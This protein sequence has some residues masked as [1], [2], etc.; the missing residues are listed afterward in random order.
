MSDNEK[1]YE[2]EALSL[3]RTAFFGV[4]LSTTATL[5][6]VISVPMLYNY[7]QHV[8]SIMQ[9][10]VD[11]C[12]SRSGSIWREVTHTQGLARVPDRS[13]RSR[14]Y[15]KHGGGKCC[16]C[17]VSPQ[18]F[19]G[20]PGQDGEPG[21][22]G[23]P[24]LPGRDG[25]GTYGP[26]PT[27]YSY[28]YLCFDCPEAP[29]GPPGNPGPR[30]PNGNPGLNGQPGPAGSP[31]AAGGAGLQGPPGI[32]GKPGNRGPRGAPGILREIPGPRGPPGPPGPQ[33]PTGDDGKP[34]APGYN[35]V[36]GGPG[37]PGI[38]GNPGIPGQ[39]GVRGDNGPDGEQ[40]PPGDCSHCPP[41][42]T[43]PGY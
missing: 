10:E 21:P 33:G 34:G 13:K 2:S 11:F 36:D 3:R 29:A 38:N 22:D 25:G 37:E 16:G 32:A 30:G 8:Q 28:P 18:G 19:P 12:K 24:G 20:N 23:K 5:I 42:R 17:G 35:G 15:S 27:P 7:I 40:G 9:N 43:A 1:H 26:E 4:A 41:P 14:P 39:P 31:G 6:C